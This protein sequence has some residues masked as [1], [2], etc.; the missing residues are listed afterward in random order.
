MTALNGGFDDYVAFD[1]TTL[2]INASNAL[3]A[4]GSQISFPWSSWLLLATLI[5]SIFEKRVGFFFCC[6]LSLSFG[7][8]SLANSNSGTYDVVVQVG[9]TTIMQSF[10]IELGEGVV[11][12]GNFNFYNFNVKFDDSSPNNS[13]IVLDTLGLYSYMNLNCPNNITATDIAMRG[14]DTSIIVDANDNVFLGFRYYQG[15]VTLNSQP[16][17]LLSLT[18]NCTWQTNGN[19]R[20]GQCSSAPNTLVVTAGGDIIVN[21]GNPCS[22]NTALQDYVPPSPPLSTT[23]P[24]Y[25]ISLNNASLWSYRTTWGGSTDGVIF[26]ESSNSFGILLDTNWAGQNLWAACDQCF[27]YFRP[28]NVHTVS[29]SFK[30]NSTLVSSLAVALMINPAFLGWYQLPDDTFLS[31]PGQWI[32]LANLT[33]PTFGNNYNTYT[34]HFTI[35]SQYAYYSGA[36]AHDPSVTWNLYQNVNPLYASIILNIALSQSAGFSAPYFSIEDFTITSSPETIVPPANL[37]TNPDELVTIPKMNTTLDPNP[38]GLACPWNEPN[39]TLWEDPATWGGSVPSPVMAQIVLPANTKVL[40]TSCSFNPND[41]Y[42]L[43][44]IPPT[45]ELIFDD[46]PITLNVRNIYVQGQLRIGSPTC[47]LY[48]NLTITFYGSQTNADMISI[49][50]GSKGIGVANGGF[51]RKNFLV[52]QQIFQIFLKQNRLIF[53]VNNII[54]HGVDWLLLF[55]LETFNLFFKMM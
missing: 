12:G 54:I 36:F 33:G 31:Q 7:Y 46:A 43:I 38:R 8:V 26:Q 15:A 48:S 44:S 14:T 5:S 32:T 28:N 27:Y 16:G 25:S 22:A 19:V 3:R 21:F 52:F 55:N 6:L 35:S 53:M 50:M 23:L 4:S 30:T 10:S 49:G 40:V 39:L 29:L 47:R 13:S 9:S 41:I 1:G 34:G 18:G 51:V 11:D 20:S 37:I 24:S 2:S 45:S 42:N 17:A